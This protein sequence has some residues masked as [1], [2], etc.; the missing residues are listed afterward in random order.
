[1]GTRLEFISSLTKCGC[2][3]R[4][5]PDSRL[6]E[7]SQE[8][9]IS[10]YSLSTPDQFGFTFTTPQ[11]L[12]I[13][14]LTTFRCGLYYKKAPISCQRSKW[15]IVRYCDTVIMWGNL[16]VQ[17]FPSLLRQNE[18]NRMLVWNM[19]LRSQR[20]H[21]LGRI[22]HE[23]SYLEFPGFSKEKNSVWIYLFSPLN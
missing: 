23:T 3:A 2:I 15:Y 9:C 7:S 12:K 6:L 16:L 5:V 20:C 17:F 13:Q 11:Y 22:I 18:V 21:F 1:M 19:Q 14:T 4:S 10:Y 8:M